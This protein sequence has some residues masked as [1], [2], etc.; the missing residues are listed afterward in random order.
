MNINP[1]DFIEYQIPSEISG[2]EK[3]LL[4]LKDLIKENNLTTLEFLKKFEI[5]KRL[6]IV[7]ILRGA[8]P[9]PID[10]EELK[11]MA[12]ILNMS[13]DEFFEMW[14]AEFIQYLKK[15]KFD[16]EKNKD[17]LNSMLECAYK[18]ISESKI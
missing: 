11:N 14:K 9:I 6:E 18:K 5:K 13:F 15:G 8:Q 10:F 7:D 2:Y 12:K 17:L 3:N 16:T 4:T 1:E